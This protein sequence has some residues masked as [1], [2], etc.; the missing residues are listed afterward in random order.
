MTLGLKVILLCAGFLCIS[1]VLALVGKRLR[2]YLIR[3]D[4]YNV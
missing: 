1:I 4:D 2:A 3:P